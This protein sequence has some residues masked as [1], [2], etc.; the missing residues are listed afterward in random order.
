MEGSNAFGKRVSGDVSTSVKFDQENNYFMIN[1]TTNLE[2][3]SEFPYKKITIGKSTISWDTPIID[4]IGK[5][6]FSGSIDRM[7]GEM[8][9]NYFS[10]LNTGAMVTITSK[11]MCERQKS[12]RF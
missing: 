5:G 11:L 6:S 10:I 9:T 4:F 1:D 7:T 3:L 2:Q 8:K 12:N